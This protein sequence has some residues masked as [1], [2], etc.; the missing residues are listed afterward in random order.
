[1]G[2]TGPKPKLTLLQQICVSHLLLNKLNKK[3]MIILNL[4]DES[5]VTM[6]KQPLL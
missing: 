3:I 2:R 1:M 6:G 5:D 4:G